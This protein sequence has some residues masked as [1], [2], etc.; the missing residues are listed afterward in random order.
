MVLVIGLAP[1]LARA[2]CGSSQCPLDAHGAD[3]LARRSAAPGSLS[4]GRLS[5]DVAYQYLDQD[6]PRVGSRRAAVGALV[7]REDEIRT[8]N[9]ITNLTVRGAISERWSLGASMP[10]V[11][12][13]HSHIVN[14]AGGG[15]QRQEFRYHGLGDLSVLGHWT[16]SGSDHVGT[17]SLTLQAGIK[18][19]TGLRH[20]EAID[21]EEPEPPARPG[22]GSVDG[23]VGAHIM[24]VLPGTHLDGGTAEVPIFASALLRL[25]GRGTEGYRVGNEVQLSVGG[26]YPLVDRLRFQGQVNARFAARDEVGTTDA[27]RE[28]TGGR[29]LY[30]SPG[31]QFD[32]T[33]EV[34]FTAFLQVPVYQRVNRIQLAAPVNFWFGVSYRRPM[35]RAG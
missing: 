15:S 21:G 2:S 1:V 12:R 4:L 3:P 5:M 25:N 30:A 24:R 33:D 6:Q 13:F 31:L 26:S 14:E 9:R 35:R 8:I 22:S 29:W 17:T 27:T 20:V 10:F 18:L 32:A 7:S 28:N 34:G 23:L 11:D 16:P 19:P